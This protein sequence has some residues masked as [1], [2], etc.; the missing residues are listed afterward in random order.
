MKRVG[1]VIHLSP[2]KRVGRI[3]PLS[4]EGDFFGYKSESEGKAKKQ[5]R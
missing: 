4:R 3:V 2:S 1:H 5:G